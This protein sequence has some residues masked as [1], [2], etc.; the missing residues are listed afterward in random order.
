MLQRA[1]TDTLGTNENTVSLGKGR[2]DTKKEPNGN[3]GTEKSKSNLKFDEGVQRQNG[4]EIS[5]WVNVAQRGMCL[6]P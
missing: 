1:V 5:I 6:F 2:E 4:G 3:F